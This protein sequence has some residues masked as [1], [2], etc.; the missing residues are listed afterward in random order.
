MHIATKLGRMVSYFNWLLRIKLLDPFGHL[1]LLDLGTIYYSSY[2]HQTWQGGDLP[3]GALVDVVTWSLN[4]VV[5][6]DHVTN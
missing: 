3:W 4:Y 1:V 6:F 5:L 2:G